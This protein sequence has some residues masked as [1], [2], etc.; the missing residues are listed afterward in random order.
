MQDSAGLD[1]YCAAALPHNQHGR[2]I[3]MSYI[4]KIEWTDVTW[5]PVRGRTKISPGCAAGYAGA[6]A[7]SLRGVPGQPLEFDFD[8]RLVPVKIGDPP[9]RSS[10]Q[11]TFVNSMSD[12]FHESVSDDYIERV[13]R[14]MEAASWNPFQVLSKRSGRLLGLL[15]GQLRFAATLPHI[16]WGV[17]VDTRRHGLPRV[18]EL[19]RALAA[20]RFLSV[21]P[22]LEDLGAFD[23]SRID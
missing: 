5:N 1:G 14:I 19:R 2:P 22:L 11:R 20:V 8:P 7:E 23:L 13:V 4:S 10:P 21:E 15:S 6:F 16:S 9:R 18:D 17:S 12:L 3:N